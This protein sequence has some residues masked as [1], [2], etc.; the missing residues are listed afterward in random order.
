LELPSFAH[1]PFSRRA[2]V[3]L[4]GAVV[5]PAAVPAHAASVDPAILVES[6]APDVSTPEQERATPPEPC[7]ASTICSLKDKV[8]YRTAGWSQ[9]FCH[10]IAQGVLDS[11]KR[12][13]IS[14][15]ML[16][17]VMINES[18]MDERAAPV[19]MKNGTIYAK[20]SGLMGIRCVLKQGR[21][22]NGYVKG[23]AWKKVMDP[24]T[25]IELGARELARWR[26]GGAVTKVTV[27]VR[28]GGKIVERQKY[29]PCQHKTHAYW[30]HYNHGPIYIGH[31]PARHYPHRV[32]V[33]EY[34]IAQAL[35]VEATELKQVPR[36]TMHDKG[37]RE[38]TVDRPVEPRFRKLCEQI[39]EVGGQCASVATLTSTN[40]LN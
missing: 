32:A 17:A 14:P 7:L 16:L 31:G 2:I 37:E 5:V 15:S 18:D 36:I 19:T 30:A 34:A 10:R 29:V 8:R 25:N 13:D 27:R 26:K 6:A 39:H 23:M 21:C 20:D 38:R 40:T 35:N 33:L 1:T 22:T 3:A 11:A 4:A 12:N 28:S 24:F 9:D